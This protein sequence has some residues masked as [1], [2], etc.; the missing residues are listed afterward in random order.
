[1]QLDKHMT[2]DTEHDQE[3]SI[4]REAWQ[5]HLNHKILSLSSPVIRHVYVMYLTPLSTGYS[6]KDG[7]PLPGFTCQDCRAGR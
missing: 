1:M 2:S 7:T 3:K 4:F 6:E 5:C